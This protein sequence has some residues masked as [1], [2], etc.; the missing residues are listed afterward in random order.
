MLKISDPII[1]QTIGSSV[2]INR[3]MQ[4]CFRI[5]CFFISVPPNQYKITKILNFELTHHTKSGNST[6][7][8]MRL[9][10]RKSQTILFEDISY[11]SHTI[12]AY[13]NYPS[14]G[15]N[16]SPKKNLT[17]SHKIATIINSNKF[18]S[19]TAS[20]ISEVSWKPVFWPCYGRKLWACDIMQCYVCEVF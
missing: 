2:Q 10:L 18:L 17:L 3:S 1:K 7:S 6:V 4:L 20:F 14:I 12:I 19:V 13:F 11:I 16:F 15:S 9:F 5:S 8:K